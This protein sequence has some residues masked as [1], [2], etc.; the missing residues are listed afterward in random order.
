M[1][2]LILEAKFLSPRFHGLLRDKT[3]EWPPSPFRFF[4]ALLNGAMQSGM[5]SD[6][7][8]SA[9]R[10]LET[11]GAP[12][13]YAPKTRSD[14]K[15]TTYVPNNHADYERD[16]SKLKTPKE[17]RPSV[18]I[19]GASVGY[20]WT[21]P[22]TDETARNSE[23][24]IRAARRMNALGWGI[25]TVIGNGRL[26]HADM[27]CPVS[28]ERWDPTPERQ[29][30]RRPS[31]LRVPVPGALD[32]L[33]RCHSEFLNRAPQGEA[34]KARRNPERYRTI[35]YK[36]STE[37]NKRYYQAFGIEAYQPRAGFFALRNAFGVGDSIRKLM[38][39]SINRRGYNEEFGGGAETYLA[40]HIAKQE[41][42]VDRISCIP[43]PSY[44]HSHSDGRIRR[45][46]IAE[47]ASGSGKVAEWA[48]RRLSAG[49]IYDN[50][51]KEYR[52]LLVEPGDTDSRQIDRKYTNPSKTWRSVTPVIL[53]GTDKRKRRKAEAQILKTLA[54]AGYNESM[55]ADW[56]ISKTPHWKN[57]LHAES[58]NIPP[59]FIGRGV[60]HLELEFKNK[61]AGPV[62]IGAGRFRGLGVMAR[63]D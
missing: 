5:D 49:K 16:L 40:G 39:I 12:T 4:Q 43:L 15:L 17:V 47:P 37:P 61:V 29:Y 27:D 25:D 10:W 62:A 20:I 58:Y 6:A 3:P 19:D 51:R 48:R 46:L 34:P 33:L 18:F 11:Q 26:I 35:T 32:D 22:D 45:T 23:T 54:Q 2:K 9:F 50:E 14:A 55:I 60:W 63:T 13:I 31:A 52:G 30:R 8:K 1:K 36:K 57:G 38:C 28:G 59:E 41:T 7:T 42:T 56:N 21:L 44:G 24:L 53:P